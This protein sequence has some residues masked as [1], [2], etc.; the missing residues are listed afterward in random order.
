MRRRVN[1][2]ASG[3]FLARK[4]EG[5]MQL[6]SKV[7]FAGVM[8]LALA[9]PGVGLAQ[10]TR[11][12]P[13]LPPPAP[14][15]PAPATA[16]PSAVL[17]CQM[18]PQLPFSR[19]VARV[20]NVSTVALAPGSTITVFAVQAGSSTGAVALSA[21]LPPGGSVNVPMSGTAVTASGCVANAG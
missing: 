15:A 12:P 5:K 20:T 11:T 4:D 21:P 6:A 10:A 14:A 1:G 16:V 19:P 7:W 3:S 8:V 18:I 2:L 9:A 17:N 13:R